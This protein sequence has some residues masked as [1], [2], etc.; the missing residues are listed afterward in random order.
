MNTTIFVIDDDASVRKAFRRVIALAGHTVEVFSSA[1]AYLRQAAPDGPGCLVLD[2]RMPGMS[3]LDLQRSV[4]AT[5]HELPIVFV[6]GHG[7]DQ[8]R[9]QALSGGAVAV[10]DKPVDMGELL[11]AIAQA[12]RLSVGT[13]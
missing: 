11:S 2:I 8:A 5:P 10:I 13:P 3:G 7:D 6:T 12:L 4:K 1:E 9:E